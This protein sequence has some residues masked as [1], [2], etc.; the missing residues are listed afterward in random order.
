MKTSQQ[1]SNQIDEVELRHSH[2]VRVSG[3][4]CPARRR[5]KQET[6]EELLERLVNPQITLH[7]TSVILRV[8]PATVRNY[9]KAGFLPCERTPG[10][11][12]RFRL[13]AVLKLFNERECE[14]NA[15][16]RR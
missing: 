5:I 11:Q 2:K 6:R 1:L 15:R 14:R 4:N 16:R 3:E 12:R 13:K 8:C 10:G 9:C 7:E